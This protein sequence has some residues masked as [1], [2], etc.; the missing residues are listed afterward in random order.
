MEALQSGQIAGAALDVFEVEPLRRKSPLH[1]QLSSSTSDFWGE[2]KTMKDNF[3]L[4]ANQTKSDANS[5]TRQTGPE[6]S[7][8]TVSFVLA[9]SG[10]RQAIT[11]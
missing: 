11:V 4:T 7:H 2:L 5:C 3:A 1:T 9:G 6:R 8:A 10:T